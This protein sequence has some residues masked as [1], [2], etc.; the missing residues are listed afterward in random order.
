MIKLLSELICEALPTGPMA[1]QL[2]GS[3]KKNN[4]INYRENPAHF[5]KLLA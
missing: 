2:L 5:G 1:Y 4:N 3:N